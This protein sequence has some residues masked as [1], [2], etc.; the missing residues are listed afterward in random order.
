MTKA[1]VVKEAK[2]IM[3]GRSYDTAILIWKEGQSWKTKTNFDSSDVDKTNG[4]VLRYENNKEYTLKEVSSIIVMKIRGE[5][6]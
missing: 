1:N 3:T 4:I 6:I 5:L 2:A